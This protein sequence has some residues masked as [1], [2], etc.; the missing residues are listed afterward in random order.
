MSEIT[1]EIA[2]N[3]TPESNAL[4]NKISGMSD[5]VQGFYSSIEGDDFETK[6]VVLEALTDSVPLS[7]N[8]NKVIMVQ[9]VI[10]QMVEML[11]TNSGE[12]KP[13]PRV[14]LIDEDGKAFHGIS[15]PLFRDVEQWLGT[16]GKPSTWKGSLP[17][18]VTKAGSGNSQYFKASISRSPKK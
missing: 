10:V 13:Q 14:V 3:T 15:Q 5:G 1:N 17:V 8:L 11:D 9:N 6:L 7:E 18:K 2:L 12:M 16:L 4:A